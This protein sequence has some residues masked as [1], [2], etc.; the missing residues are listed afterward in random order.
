[1][2]TTRRFDAAFLVLLVLSFGLS[3]ANAALTDGGLEKQS[4]FNAPQHSAGIAPGP[5]KL[6]DVAIVQ[7]YT[8]P[9]YDWRGLFAVHAGFCLTLPTSC[10]WWRCILLPMKSANNSTIGRR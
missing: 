5:V 9:T 2:T 8:A 1:M 6:V 10:Q 4:W 7:V 3:V